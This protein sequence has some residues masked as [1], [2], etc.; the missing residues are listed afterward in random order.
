MSAVTDS[1]AKIK[2]DKENKPGVS[3]LMTI[4]SAISIFHIRNRSEI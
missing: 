4:Y 1:E 3:N 2:Y